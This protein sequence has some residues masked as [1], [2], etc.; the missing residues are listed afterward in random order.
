MACLL[1]RVQG[2]HLAS[3]LFLVFLLGGCDSEPQYQYVDF[4]DY[5]EP[6]RPGDPSSGTAPLRVAVSAM[7]SPR[8]TIEYYQALLDYLSARIDQPIEM[9][10]RK[11][12]YEI[13]ELF[14]QDRLDL[15]FIC[16]GPYA[17]SKESYGFDAVAAPQVRGLPTYQ[18]YLIVK[19]E[20]EY[21]ALEDLR[22]K[23]FAFTDPDSNTGSLVPLFWLAELGETPAT[24]FR[25]TIHTYSH[26]NS[27]K[28]VSRG[29]V[30]AAAV[31]GHIWEYY[32]AVDPGLTGATRVI[33]KS[34]PF[35]SPPLVAASSLTRQEKARIQ[36]VLTSMHEDEAGRRILERLMIDRFLVPEEA[37]YSSV[38]AMHQFLE[39][40]GDPHAAARPR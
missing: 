11:T 21:D 1:P 23:E 6:E 4:K 26:D 3:C 8:E 31:D 29:L 36:A 27:I 10:Q 30:D 39:K 38:K 13:N 33:K 28:A 2:F 7:I 35:G 32:K 40:R 17:T 9:V 19:S 24:F 5:V 12:Y 16:T 20:S 25:Q 22:G 18:S 37:W 15:A 14:S 34:E